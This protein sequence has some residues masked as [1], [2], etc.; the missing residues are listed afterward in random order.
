M[1][2][3][4]LICDKCGDVVPTK[5]THDCLDCGELLCETCSIPLG[6]AFRCADC[7]EADEL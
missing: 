6:E 3:D 5:E 1:A 2:F 4:E 7:E